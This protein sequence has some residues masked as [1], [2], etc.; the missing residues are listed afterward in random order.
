M[1][2]DASNITHASPGRRIAYDGPPDELGSL[3]TSLNAMLERL[4]HSYS[5]QR[6][7]IADAS[8][9]LRTP[10]AII[11]GNVELLEGGKLCARRLEDARSR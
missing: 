4:E 6:R 1:A 2:A 3:A 10:V 9:E 8:H 11:R 5:D 7:F